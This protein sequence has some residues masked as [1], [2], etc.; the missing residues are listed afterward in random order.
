MLFNLFKNA[1]DAMNS[2]TY[3]ND[4]PKL[5][6]RLKSGQGHVHILV[7]DNGPGIPREICQHIFEP[8]FTTK[9]DKGTG[10]GL[11]I[12]YSIITEDHGGHMEVE[13]EPD[14]GTKFIIKLPFRQKDRSMEQNVR[15]VEC[16]VN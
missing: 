15:S 7:E 11:S 14:K 13:T 3:E 9:K 1:S 8:F 10:L 12:S 16:E 4:F 5:I 2:K 6:L